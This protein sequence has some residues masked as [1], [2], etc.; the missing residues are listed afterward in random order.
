MGRPSALSASAQFANGTVASIEV[1]GSCVL[2]A[3]GKI[4]VPNHLLEHQ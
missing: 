1:G 3:E 2:I 4:E